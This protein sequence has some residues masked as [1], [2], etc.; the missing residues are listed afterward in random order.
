MSHGWLL[1]VHIDPQPQFG[2]GL[3]GT[4]MWVSAV[5]DMSKRTFRQGNHLEFPMSSWIQ[6]SQIT[7]LMHSPVLAVHSIPRSK[8]FD[9]TTYHAIL[10]FAWREL[11]WAKE[12]TIMMQCVIAKWHHGR[13]FG[14]GLNLCFLLIPGR[15]DMFTLGWFPQAQVKTHYCYCY[16]YK[17]QRQIT[18]I[19][20]I[21]IV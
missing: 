18:G 12:G 5:A 2:D 9:N 3:F 4:Q 20:K 8:K 10:D 13:H 1:V 15:N 16:N 11:S 17:D 21:C 19:E 14:I 7:M 6:M